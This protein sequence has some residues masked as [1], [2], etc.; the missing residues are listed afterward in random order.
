MEHCVQVQRAM[1]SKVEK[2]KIPCQISLLMSTA[3][4]LHNRYVFDVV[5][6]SKKQ[7]GP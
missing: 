3:F 1:Q 6:H 7:T 4:I 5:M 2:H